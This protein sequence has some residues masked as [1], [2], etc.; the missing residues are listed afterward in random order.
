MPNIPEYKEK[1]KRELTEVNPNGLH[2]FG[3]RMGE[4]KELEKGT[5]CI[6]SKGQHL[7]I[8]WR[9]LAGTYYEERIITSSKMT[10]PI[11]CTKEGF[12]KR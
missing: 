9:T 4:K 1:S 2:V 12:H 7:F 10:K 8:R 3:I 6:Y 11:K 5:A